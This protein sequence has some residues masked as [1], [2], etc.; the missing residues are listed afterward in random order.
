MTQLPKQ[1]AEIIHRIND[2]VIRDW[3]SKDTTDPVLLYFLANGNT[4]YH[5]L[6]MPAMMEEVKTEQRG[7]IQGSNA[8]KLQETIDVGTIGLAR[9]PG[10]NY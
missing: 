4:F 9:K 1:L 10:Y 3:M 7:T 5:N 8:K 2:N 6:F